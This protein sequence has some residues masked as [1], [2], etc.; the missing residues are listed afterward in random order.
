MKKKIYSTVI[1]FIVVVISGYNVYNSKLTNLSDL[2]LSN[3]EALAQ[4]GESS[5]MKISCD[6]YSVVIKC[7]YM[8]SSC[9][10]LWTTSIGYGNSTGI[11]GTCKCGRVH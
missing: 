6:M 5:D 9:Y 8:C 2:A 1:L 11:K 10:T 7:Q 4:Y 3:I